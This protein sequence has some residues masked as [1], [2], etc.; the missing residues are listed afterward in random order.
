MIDNNGTKLTLDQRPST[1]SIHDKLDKLVSRHYQNLFV[2]DIQNDCACVTETYDYDSGKYVCYLT[3]DGPLYTLVNS[4]CRVPVPMIENISEKDINNL[5]ELSCLYAKDFLS[6]DIKP[7]KMLVSPASPAPI[8]FE[9]FKKIT[10]YDLYC[11]HSGYIP[12]MIFGSFVPMDCVYF[13]PEPEFFGVIST[14]VG[15]YGV[16]CIPEH[17]LKVKI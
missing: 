10:G 15:G 3:K 2:Q 16:F 8:L 6:N 17:I 13:T 1:K 7:F 14:N 9:I 11:R 4:T 5:L 12:D